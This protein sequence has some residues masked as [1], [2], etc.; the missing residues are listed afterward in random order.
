MAGV[1]GNK[2][3]P[4]KL[5]KSNNFSNESIAE[6]QPSTIPSPHKLTL[7]G[8]L[9]LGQ[10]I[11]FNKSSGNTH[12][13]FSGINHLQQEQTVLFDQ[14]QKELEKSLIELREAIKGL[15]DTT[16]NLGKDVQNVV[17]SEIVDVSEYQVNFFVRV[18][19]FILGVKQS[20]SETSLWV[21]S[22]AAKKKKRNYFWNTAKNKKKGGDAF[23]F[24]DE[25]SVARSVG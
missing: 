24:S 19:N 18:R 14:R 13:I 15:A 1:V 3:D 11:E 25:S 7:R 10:T 8:I 23:M 2:K 4:K 9:G 5:H 22:F 6:N 17:V 21:Q 12:E 20:I 16:D